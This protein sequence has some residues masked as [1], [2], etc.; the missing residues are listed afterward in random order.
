MFG[1]KRKTK[2]Y[3]PDKTGKQ[4]STDNHR[5]YDNAIVKPV[6][7]K[8]TPVDTRITMGHPG[9]AKAPDIKPASHNSIKHIQVVNQADHTN[10]IMRADK[11]LILKITD[12]LTTCERTITEH[13][14][15]EDVLNGSKHAERAVLISL[16]K[17]AE[18]TP[19]PNELFKSYYYG[20]VEDRNGLTMIYNDMCSFYSEDKKNTAINVITGQRRAVNAIIEQIEIINQIPAATPGVEKKPKVIAPETRA[21]L[22]DYIYTFKTT[23]ENNNGEIEEVVIFSKDYFTHLIHELKIIDSEIKLAFY[24]KTHALMYLKCTAKIVNDEIPGRVW[25]N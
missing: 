3:A 14:Y 19:D 2:V 17:R 13:P 12:L 24:C 20:L 18:L 16:K 6:P 15:I 8:K 21:F 25:L 5:F 1:R 22:Q 10:F 23:I 9:T 11:F 4:Y 7:P